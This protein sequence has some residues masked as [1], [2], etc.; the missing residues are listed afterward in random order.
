[1]STCTNNSVRI[2]DKTGLKIKRAVKAE[3]ESAGI[4]YMQRY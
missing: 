2:K 4:E 3:N 1:M